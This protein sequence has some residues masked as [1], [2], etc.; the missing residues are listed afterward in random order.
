[1]VHVTLPDQP[2]EEFI[3]LIPR[4]RAHVN[5]LMREGIITSYALAQDRSY[6]WITMLAETP[7]EVFGII[8]E[9]PM[10]KFFSVEIR[11][12]MFFNHASLIIPQMS[13]N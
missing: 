4:Q 7:Q 13:M 2:T 3:S 12:L 11:E 5:N 9:F 10:R 6:L 8:N 1:M